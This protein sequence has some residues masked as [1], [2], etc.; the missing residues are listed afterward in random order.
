M[1]TEDI[2]YTFGESFSKSN[3]FV[4]DDVVI[5][6]KERATLDSPLHEIGGHLYMA[7][8]KKE[9]PAKYSRIVALAIEHPIRHMIERNYPNLKGEDLGEEIFATLFGLEGQQSSLTAVEG[10]DLDNGQ[11]IWKGIKNFVKDIYDFFNNL[12]KSAFNIPDGFDLNTNQSLSGIINDLSNEILFGDGSILS[13]VNPKIQGDIKNKINN[14]TLNEV[15]DKL[16][17]MNFRKIICT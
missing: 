14:L 9:D 3:A 16:D 13:D 15:F 2:K 7:K 12:F 10:N 4:I 11:S 5:L 1:S 17:Q 6:N 8:L